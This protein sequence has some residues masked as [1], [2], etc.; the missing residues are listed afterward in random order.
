MALLLSILSPER[1]LV[2]DCEV[3]EVTLFTSE[4]MIQI[5]P[6]HAAMVGTLET[7]AF[8][9]HTIARE[10]VHGFISAGFFEVKDDKLSLMAEIVELQDEISA[11]HARAEQ[12]HAEELLKQADLD[13][14]S[15]KK[16]QAQLDR[17]IA[18]QHVS[19]LS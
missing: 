14:H 18:R 10:D 19:S 9:Y 5:L 17:A 16:Y 11:E 6:G 7:G 4:G 8:S 1:R 13:E 2:E 12:A 3:E 15:F